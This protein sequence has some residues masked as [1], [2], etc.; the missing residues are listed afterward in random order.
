[1]LLLKCA[2]KMRENVLRNGQRCADAQVAPLVTGKER[3]CGQRS[4]FQFLDVAGIFQENRTGRGKRDPGPASV[5]QLNAKVLFQSFDLKGDG[6]L[7]E[8]KFLRRFA[9]V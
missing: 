4:R 8:A 9:K 7:G 2:Q 1:M 3:Q 6:G 5:E